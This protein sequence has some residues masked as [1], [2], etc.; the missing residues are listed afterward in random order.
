MAEGELRSWRRRSIC[1]GASSC[2]GLI[3]VVTCSGDLQPW[4]RLGVGAHLRRGARSMGLPAN[5]RVPRTDRTP[6]RNKS[7]TPVG[8]RGVH[9][10]GVHPGA[11]SVGR[12]FEAGAYW[13]WAPGQHPSQAAAEERP[14]RTLGLTRARIRAGSECSGPQREKETR[15]LSWR[16]PLRWPVGF[17]LQQLRML[18]NSHHPQS[19]I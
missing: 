18:A 2:C 8:A 5:Y 14:F 1:T 15:H 19:V 9:G 17:L 11:S 3:V 16:G 13:A 7:R 4:P 6:S 12:L 10:G